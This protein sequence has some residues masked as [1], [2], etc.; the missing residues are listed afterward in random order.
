VIGDNFEVDDLE[1]TSTDSDS[2]NGPSFLPFVKSLTDGTIT[3]MADE[4]CSISKV[5]T[6]VAKKAG[7]SILR[8]N[9]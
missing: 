2:D 7:G 4:H 9:D 8:D 5:K 3:L 1:D 6:L